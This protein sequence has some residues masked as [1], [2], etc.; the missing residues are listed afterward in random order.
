MGHEYF[1]LQFDIL[2]ESNTYEVV[3][4]VKGVNLKEAIAGALERRNISIE[5]ISVYLAL[6]NTPLPLVV[7]SYPLGGNQLHVKFKGKILVCI[8]NTCTKHPTP[9]LGGDNRGHQ[10]QRVDL[11]TK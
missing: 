10:K 9:T 8:F 11:R 1:T 4:A 2:N 7:D 6:S 3:A 5:K